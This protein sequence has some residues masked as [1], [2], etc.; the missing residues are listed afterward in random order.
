[1]DRKGNIGI[2]ILVILLIIG[3]IFWYT[4]KVR[5]ASQNNP[6]ATTPEIVGDVIVNSSQDFVG[7]VKPVVQGVN[8][9][10]SNQSEEPPINNGVTNNTYS[11]P[12][13]TI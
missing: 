12:N 1:M 2:T 6:D 10:F 11:K 13:E 3:G 4:D 8:E 5:S 9:A 7:V